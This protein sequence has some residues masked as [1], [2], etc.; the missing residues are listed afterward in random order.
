MRRIVALGASLAALGAAGC[1]SDEDFAN[2]PRPPAIA[3]IT[4]SIGRDAVSVSPN[5]LGAGPV[6]LLVVNQ[7][8]ARQAVTF[9]GAGGNGFEVTS[10]PI[11]PQDT[12]TLRVDVTRGRA[13]VRVDGDGIREARLTV[14][15]ERPS[16]QNDLLQP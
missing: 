7:T 15:P 14:G 16:A 1:G 6:S 3:T 11:L 12:A 2:E 4:A 9:A 8:D 5:R 10:G 13:V